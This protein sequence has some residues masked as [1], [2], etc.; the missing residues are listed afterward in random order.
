[1]KQVI[2]ASELE[3]DICDKLGLTHVRRIIIDLPYDSVGTIDV[4]F[5]TDERFYEVDFKSGLDIKLDDNRQYI[6]GKNGEPV[7]VTTHKD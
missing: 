7:D 6:R 2:R 4:E 1:M 3:K 5:L